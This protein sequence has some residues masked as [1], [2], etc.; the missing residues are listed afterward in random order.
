M[1]DECGKMEIFVPR[2]RL[3]EN[4][5]KNGIKLVPRWGVETSFIVCTGCQI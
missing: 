5:A 2:L 3:A 1:N 4:R